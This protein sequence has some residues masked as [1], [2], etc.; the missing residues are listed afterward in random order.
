[1]AIGFPKP[2][3]TG[4]FRAYMDLLEAQE[5][6]DILLEDDRVAWLNK[7]FGA[8]LAAR[9][10]AEP[11]PVWLDAINQLPGEDIGAKAVN[12]FLQWDP[13]RNKQNTR[14]LITLYLKNRADLEDYDDS[15]TEHLRLFAAAKPRLANKNLDSYPGLGDLWQA[16][17][18]FTQGQSV[19]AND[20]KRRQDAF[21]RSPKQTT[22]VHD[23][24]RL[25]IVS[26]KTFESAKFWG[27]NT[28]W[29]TTS[30][31]HTFRSYHERGPL[32]I[33]L[34]K[35][36]NRRWQF[37]FETKQF[38]D[39][40][41]RP[42]NVAKFVD[43]Y[44]QIINFLGPDR[45]AGMSDE[46]GL[47]FFP[48]RAAG[49]S[50]EQLAAGV[51]TYADLMVVPEQ[52]RNIEP[53]L[54]SVILHAEKRFAK[55]NDKDRCQ[56]LD[57]QVGPVMG[58]YRDSMTADYLNGILGRA[59]WVYHYA[60][61]D[62]L[63]DPMQERAAAQFNSRGGLAACDA[64]RFFIAMRWTPK[65]A[66]YYWELYARYSDNI[67]LQ[68]IP[69][70]HR[71]TSVIAS[72]LLR[73][74]NEITTHADD[75]SDAVAVDMV[76]R[77]TIPQLHRLVSR[78]P[79]NVL[80]ASVA[81]CLWQ[82]YRSLPR[83]SGEHE[84]Q[85]HNHVFQAFTLFPQK[86]WPKAAATRIAMLL[87]CPWSELP[88]PFRENID[89]LGLWAAKSSDRL[90]TIT[91]PDLLAPTLFEE[92]FRADWAAAQIPAILD[93]CDPEIVT[94]DIL[95]KA[96]KR[97]TTLTKHWNRV[98]KK[99][100]SPEFMQVVAESGHLP[101]EKAPTI[102]PAAVVSRIRE[103]TEERRLT[104]W[105]KVPSSLLTPE[106]I[107]KMVIAWPN[108]SR[109]LDES[110]FTTDL[111][112]AFLSSRMGQRVGQRETFER[113]PRSS[114]TAKTCALAVENDLL[115]EVPPEFLDDEVISKQLVARDPAE[116]DWS[117]VTAKMLTTAY[118]KLLEK[119]NDIQWL[120][121]VQ[122]LPVN[123]PA[124]SDGSVAEA[125]TWVLGRKWVLGRD[126]PTLQN[127]A[128]AVRR[129]YPTVASRDCWN[130]DCYACAVGYI[131]KI[132]EIPK[133]Y[134][135]PWIVKLGVRRDQS[136]VRQ[137]PK[138]VKWLNA[139]WHGEPMGPMEMQGFVKTY[140][141]WLDAYED[142]DRKVVDGKPGSYGIVPTRED[143]D[144]AFKIV[145][146]RSD[147]RIANVVEIVGPYLSMAESDPRTLNP[148]KSVF[149]VA[150]NTLNLDRHMQI[151]KLAQ[152]HMFNDPGAERGYIRSI[153]NIPRTKIDGTPLEWVRVSIRYGDAFYYLFDGDRPML[154]FGT[155]L[156]DQEDTGFSGG[157]R[158][159]NSYGME[160]A[161]D[162][163]DDVLK[164]MNDR[165]F[166]AGGQAFRLT[167]MLY[168]GLRATSN[169]G[170]MT[171]LKQRIGAVDDIV[172]WKARDIVSFTD[173][174]GLFATFKIADG[175][176]SLTDMLV[177][178][179]E[180]KIAK[181]KAAAKEILMK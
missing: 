134:S 99:F 108:V 98:P 169:R 60:D 66:A 102:T 150:V 45:F 163:S 107:E 92:I 1:L 127:A 129:L 180:E 120:K 110:A 161:L 153:Q 15:V 56:N 7:T 137:I 139:N 26:P 128:D 82:R 109:Y 143:D 77:V 65:T 64:M 31:E 36:E 177:L 80:T 124:L 69:K 6:A 32:F 70:E 17:E 146:F 147:D 74:S 142:V 160:R 88:M 2:L 29:C 89:F 154:T 136:L 40:A 27:V 131:S 145:M 52:Q 132:D 67:H 156:Q 54:T 83:A 8:K 85:S 51:H 30:A 73:N 133:K 152:I 46:L 130:E 168:L 44:P 16:V 162:R 111:L 42:I 68:D 135:K 141:G 144:R 178:G 91:D 47:R 123:H 104:E 113:F 86:L 14:W 4:M 18:P 22:I 103:L 72:C 93:G 9:I 121:I 116:I 59:G 78:L 155:L 115:N 19:S 151:Q 50:I 90:S 38:M 79:K 43:R 175:E 63:T 34:D 13:S 94:P 117:R 71:T 76:T 112:L 157:G 20:E 118:D 58:Y 53:F 24:P 106:F 87:D 39:E 165:R 96:A 84:K 101:L 37:H 179:K 11:D 138:P 105:N 125:I 159:F 148:V 181:A 172:I 35:K 95:A 33:I 48:E 100:H 174:E 28:R 75:I 170:W 25:L 126:K 140:D 158:V 122:A 171:L 12:W 62:L 164:F 176:M 173:A 81:D 55:D 167:P 41:D 23:D 10:S 49:M 149:E 57:E 114:W 3:N 119:N 61:P 5:Y 166:P 97:V 21:F